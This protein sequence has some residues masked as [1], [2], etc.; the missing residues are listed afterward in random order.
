MDGGAIPRF[1]RTDQE[2]ILEGTTIDEQ[3]GSPARRLG[4]TRA[5]DVASD[6]KGA[7]S[8]VH[9]HQGAGEIPTPHRRQPFGG[10]LCR[11]D[12]Q[13]GGAI[14]PKLETGAWMSERQSG[15]RLMGRA[16]LAP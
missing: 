10:V 15:D 4:V 5:L 6:L 9:R 7:G 14:N 12:T 11:R 1:G 13:P 3:L 16:G 2:G 8:V